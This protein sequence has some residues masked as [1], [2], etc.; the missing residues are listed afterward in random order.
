M[1]SVRNRRG[2]LNVFNRYPDPN[3]INYA[4]A[5]LYTDN[6]MPWSQGSHYFL[7][8]QMDL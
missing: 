7:R 6:G 8:A 2:I 3:S 5:S 4:G 1:G